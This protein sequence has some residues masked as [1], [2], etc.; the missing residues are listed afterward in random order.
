MV[1]KHIGVL[2]HPKEAWQ[3]KLGDSDLLASRVFV[4]FISGTPGIFS[5]MFYSAWVWKV[6]TLPFFVSKVAFF[7]VQ[8]SE[9]NVSLRVKAVQDC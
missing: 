3:Y 2:F 9:D 6:A 7:A 5:R 8:P 4:H 1:L